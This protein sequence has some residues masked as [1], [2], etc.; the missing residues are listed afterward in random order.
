[1][2]ACFFPG[3]KDFYYYLVSLLKKKPDNIILHF[4][5]NDAPYKSE[6]DIYIKN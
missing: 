4:G 2:K 3:A 6:D 1:M 5:T